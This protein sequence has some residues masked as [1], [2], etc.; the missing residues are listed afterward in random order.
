MKYWVLAFSL[1]MFG[2]GGGES[3][4]SEDAAAGD[5]V[6]ATQKAASGSADA[7][8]EEVESIGDAAVDAINEAQ[9]AAE[10]TGDMI[11]KSKEDIDEELKK[12][13]GAIND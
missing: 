2:C 12:A 9:E 7:V 8:E 5:V 6:E 11:E 3:D 13:E 10:A 1:F 4:S